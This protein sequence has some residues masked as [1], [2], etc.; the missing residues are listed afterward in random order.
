MSWVGKTTS[1]GSGWRFLT[2]DSSSSNAVAPSSWMGW[3]TV[4]SPGRSRRA[5]GMSS[6]PVT[7]TEP[8]T[9]AP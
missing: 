9:S 1:R 2:S 6:K 4:V 8:G 3:R 7:A 5:T